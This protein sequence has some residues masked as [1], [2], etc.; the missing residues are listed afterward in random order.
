MAFGVYPQ[1]HGGGTGGPSVLLVSD[2][3][4]AAGAF[5]L[6]QSWG[7]AYR[8][9]G[10]LAWTLWDAQGTAT[11]ATTTLPALDRWYHLVG[12][13]DS[14]SLKLYLDGTLV[15]TTPNPPTLTGGARRVRLGSGLCTAG[16]ACVG[17][18]LQG[19]LD[20]VQVYAQALAADAVQALA[21]AAAE[22]GHVLTAR[23]LVAHW[24]LD[25]GTGLALGDPSLALDTTQWTPGFYAPVQGTLAR[26]AVAPS[27]ALT[28]STWA[29]QPNGSQAYQVRIREFDANGA[30]VAEHV[31][32]A[33]TPPTTWVR[34]RYPFTTHSA[35]ATLTVELPAPGASTLRFA[36]VQV[37]LDRRL[38]PRG[39]P[40][41]VAR[42]PAGTRYLHQDHLGST[43]LVTTAAGAFAQA[44]FHAP[45]GAPWHAIG[46]LAAGQS[47]TDRHY[48]GQRSFE[49]SLGS[50]YHYQAR[51]YSPV[52]GRF[53]A[54]DP[55]VPEPGNPQAL[56]R[57]S[58]VYNNPL[59]YTDPSGY[60]RVE[61]YYRP[62]GS[63]SIWFGWYDDD[64]D[65]FH[66]RSIRRA[67]SGTRK[68]LVDDL[69][70]TCGDDA[71]TIWQQF[72][73][74]IKN[75]PWGMKLLKSGCLLP[76]TT[77]VHKG[78]VQT[79]VV[80]PPGADI[81]D[82]IKWTLRRSRDVVD[83][84]FNPNVA[85]SVLFSWAWRVRPGGVWDFKPLDTN[86][87]TYSPFGNLNYG[88]TGAALGGPSSILYFAG[89]VLETVKRVLNLKPQLPLFDERAC[90]DMDQRDDNL[91]IW[92]GIQLFWILLER[93][94]V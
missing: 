18:Y 53:L 10:Q 78:G 6:P 29:Q 27:Q 19:W 31:S 2:A 50:L 17:G 30:L 26:L 61:G 89:G 80:A 40:G 25:E 56:N 73:T 20:E 67:A 46:T 21:Q 7:F 13:V 93:G 8:P 41:H 70:V 28:V 88:A 86:P 64:E 9:D 1:R 12:T 51:W 63:N 66:W 49:G 65:T 87:E 71:C 58:Y 62:H 81:V 91:A 79:N 85:N 24:P 39:V 75:G 59:R 44:R 11:T 47:A 45:F 83:A 90:C 5:T 84:Q 32:P 55:I 82:N 23:G 38:G 4:D 36:G 3:A 33:V 14:T 74:G 68:P 43:G 42:S 22:P 94:L 35:T 92:A 76:C 77:S 37:A 54:P 15:A 72:Y 52:L 57:Y 60:A 69:F 48:T 34:S 16:M